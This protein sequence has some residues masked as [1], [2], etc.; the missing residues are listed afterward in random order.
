VVDLSAP[1]ETKIHL[2]K[3]SMLSKFNNDNSDNKEMCNPR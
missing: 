2:K 1:Y 3:K